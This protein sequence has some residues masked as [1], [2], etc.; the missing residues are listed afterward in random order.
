MVE[1]KSLAEVGLE[2]ME[3]GD[4]KNSPQEVCC[5][6]QRRNKTK[7]E[8]GIQRNNSMF[9][10]CQGCFKRKVKTETRDREG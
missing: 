2:G 4:R 8:C 3:S 5:K 9:I 7:G 1:I 6:G 10:Y